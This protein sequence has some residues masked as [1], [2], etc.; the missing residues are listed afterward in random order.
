MPSLP[1]AVRCSEA[2][3][4]FIYITHFTCLSYFDYNLHFLLSVS[5]FLLDHL[6]SS[7]SL[8]RSA[9][10]NS[11]HSSRH[12]QQSEHTNMAKKFFVFVFLFN[13]LEVFFLNCC[14]N[15]QL[16]VQRFFCLLATGKHSKS[17]LQY[18]V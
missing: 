8:Q 11:T 5:S 15:S 18:A 12:R 14:I 2:S 13:L 4:G 1:G 7:C 6:S 9:A 3:C 17:N 16:V 10:T